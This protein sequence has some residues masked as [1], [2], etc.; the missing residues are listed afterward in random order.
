MFVSGLKF[1]RTLQIN[2]TPPKFP[3][4]VCVTIQK[5]Q[6]LNINDLRRLPP[7]RHN[8]AQK[9][10]RDSHSSRLKTTRPVCPFRPLR[11]WREQ[12]A[13]RN[14]GEKL[15][16]QN[17]PA[18]TPHAPKPPSH[19]LKSEIPVRPA[20]APCVAQQGLPRL[21]EAGPHSW[22]CHTQP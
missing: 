14:R 4:Y 6:S 3:S 15:N 17:R 1:F 18:L 2:T 5:N 11:P 12:S 19:I 8:L 10:P 13:S 16:I 21:S 20:S 22:E 7:F 9:K